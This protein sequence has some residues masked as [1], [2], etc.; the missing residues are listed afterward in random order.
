MPFSASEFNAAPLN[1][2]VS[3]IGVRAPAAEA[4]SATAT[5]IDFPRSMA[6]T[7]PLPRPTTTSPTPAMDLDFDLGNTATNVASGA[8]TTAIAGATA[9]AE[10]APAADPFTA[11]AFGNADPTART[12]VN[13]PAFR[14]RADQPAE[15]APEATNIGRDADGFTASDIFGSSIVADTQPLYADTQPAPPPAQPTKPARARDGDGDMQFEKT[16]PFDASFSNLNLELDR[17]D[18]PSPTASDINGRTDIWQAMATKLDLAL[19]YSDIGD[20]DGARELLEEVVRNG[21]QAQ[22]DRARHLITEL[23]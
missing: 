23:G 1:F 8:A 17:G 12:A 15:T 20:K 10:P 9:P 7:D 5:D 4:T 13:L 11:S 14:A 3:D 18:F 2:A 16:E 22:A 19:A 6:R 21:D